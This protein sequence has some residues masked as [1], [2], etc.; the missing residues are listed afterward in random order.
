M[1]ARR[2][3]F[4]HWVEQF[5]GCGLNPQGRLQFGNWQLQFRAIGT[6]NVNSGL[7]G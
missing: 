4:P 5:N 7:N 6:R 2:A 3:S 1:Y